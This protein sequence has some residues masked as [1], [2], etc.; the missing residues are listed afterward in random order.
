MCTDSPLITTPRIS[1]F[2]S[3]FIF[4]SS[5]N[6]TKRR[7]VFIHLPTTSTANYLQ[8]GLMNVTL[9][10]NPRR[11]IIVRNASDMPGGFS[12]IDPF[13]KR[14]KKRVICCICPRID[15]LVDLVSVRQFRG[16]WGGSKPTKASSLDPIPG[17]VNRH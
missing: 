8:F 1:S 16:R 2:Q 15:S 14:Q 5:N 4:I 7:L 12:S 13:N 6:Q 11:V 9:L 17:S 10:L 3:L